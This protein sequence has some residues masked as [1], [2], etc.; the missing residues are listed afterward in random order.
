MMADDTVAP[1][2]GA[3]LNAQSGISVLDNLAGIIRTFKHALRDL[4]KI[5]IVRHGSHTCCRSSP[6]AFQHDLQEV[7]EEAVSAIEHLYISHPNNVQLRELSTMMSRG[8]L[9]SQNGRFPARNNPRRRSTPVT[10]PIRNSPPSRT[11]D[12]DDED[13]SDFETIS[14]SATFVVNEEDEEDEDESDDDGSSSEGSESDSDPY[15]YYSDLSMSDLAS[16]GASIHSDG[17]FLELL[18]ISF[19]CE[20]VQ[21]ANS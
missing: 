9:S 18:N 4:V 6:Y 21:S 3:S 16:D 12:E 14:S 7:L 5:Y 11:S 20:D 1:T 2:E 17:E 8:R 10:E 15:Y 13:S 19:P